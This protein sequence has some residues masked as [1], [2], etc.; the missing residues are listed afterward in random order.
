MATLAARESFSIPSHDG[1]PRMIGM[2]DLV[3]DSDPDIIG[4]EHLFHPAEEA[5]AMANDRR[6]QRP[7]RAMETATAAPGEVRHLPP[8]S[9]DEEPIEQPARAPGSKPA[10]GAKPTGK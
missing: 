2:G 4:R 9:F 1:M 6:G 5:A 3:E 10:P 8:P 7:N